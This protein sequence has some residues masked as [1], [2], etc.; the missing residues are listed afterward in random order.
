MKI[1]NILTICIFTILLTTYASAFGITTFYWEDRPLILNPG[2]TTDVEFIL[3][4]EQASPPINLNVE[5]TSGSDIAELTGKSVYSLSSGGSNSIKIKILIP[6][7]AKIGD[8]YNVAITATTAAE[9]EEGKMLSMGTQIGK[10]IPVVVGK[11]IEP[12][13][14]IFD[15]I[16]LENISGIAVLLGIIILALVIYKKKKK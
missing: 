8:K 9:G 5:V 13:K 7:T 2:S 10:S 3:Q 12:E 14:S 4:N 1:K 16:P 6:E 11:V 15:M